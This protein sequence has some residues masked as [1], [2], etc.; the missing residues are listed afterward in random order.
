MKKIPEYYNEQLREKAAKI[1][2]IKKDA[3]FIFITDLHVHDNAFASVPLIKRVN[4]LTGIDK[5]FGGGD[6]PYAF[7]T[8]KE[9]ISDAVNSIKYLSSVKPEIKFYNIRGNHDVTIR[10]GRESE[11]G[12]TH[13]ESETNKI[14]LSE[15]SPVTAAAPNDCVYFIDDEIEK[16]RYVIVNTSDSQSGDARKFWG[17]NYSIG[18]AQIQWLVKNA[19]NFSGGGDGWGIIVLGHVPVSEKLD[20]DGKF[21]KDFNDLLIAV[22]NKQRCK[23]GDFGAFKPELIAYICGHIH[24]DLYCRDGGVLHV[25]TGPDAYYNDDIYK[26]VKGTLTESLFSVFALDKTARK[27]RLIRFGAGEDNEYDY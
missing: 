7:G 19:F 10:Y 6:Y 11:T 23:Y 4:A 27:L 17:V 20:S 12:Y 25:S 3:A 13:P 2:D 21:Y 8:K 26:R 9:C 18:E 22:K 15:N 16:I 24:K 1:N 5:L 14:L